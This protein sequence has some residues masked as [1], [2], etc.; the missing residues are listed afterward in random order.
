MYIELNKAFYDVLTTL[1]KELKFKSD[2]EC[3]DNTPQRLS[4]MY[5]TELLK[6]YSETPE[7]ILSK[8][9]ISK[10]QDMIVVRNIPFVSLCAHHWLPFM[11]TAQFGYIPDKEIVG[12]SKIPR[13]VQCYAKRFQIQEELTQQIVDAFYSIVKPK[14]CVVVTKAVHMCAKIRGVQSHDA[15]M[16]VSAVR[17]CFTNKDQKDEFMNLFA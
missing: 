13:L 17:G 16:I 6:G 10:S 2:K 4:K 3:L 11:G 7:D 15:E 8:R 12:L 5:S 9:F 14:G 1:E